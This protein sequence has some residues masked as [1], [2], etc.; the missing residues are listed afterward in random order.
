MLG[1][2][3]IGAFADNR[4]FAH[5]FTPNPILTGL[6]DTAL[7]HHGFLGAD[8]TS[9]LCVGHELFPSGNAA[10]SIVSFSAFPPQSPSI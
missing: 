1:Q 4:L 10:P 9:L 2:F 7:E 8:H 5:R 3:F 6:A